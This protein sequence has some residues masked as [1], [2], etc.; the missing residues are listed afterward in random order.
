[1]NAQTYAGAGILPGMFEPCVLLTRDVGE[2]DGQFGRAEEWPDGAA[3]DALIIKTASPEVTE[4]GRRD[5][6][7]QYTVVVRRGTALRHGDVF[8]RE[9]NGET[10]RVTS[11]PN[12]REAPDV[13]T[14]QIARLTAEGW[15][16]P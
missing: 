9:K 16:L 13:S 6:R 1:M 2:S 4:A 7:E 8:R 5:N 10:L 11:R 15:D 14:I 12:D 3:F